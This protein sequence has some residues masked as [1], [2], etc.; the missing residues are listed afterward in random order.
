MLEV[1]VG[2]LAQDGLERGV[3]LE[4]G[5]IEDKPD[6]L[7]DINALVGADEDVV[8]GC[9]LCV[10]GLEVVDLAAAAE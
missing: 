5:R 8:V 6:D 3:G 7:G 9:E 4:P 2:G 10:S 1:V